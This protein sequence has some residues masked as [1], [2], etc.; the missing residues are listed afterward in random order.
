MPLYT[1]EEVEVDLTNMDPDSPVLWIRADPELL[2]LRN[3]AIRQPNYQWEYMLKYERDV[4]A[5]LQVRINV[6]S[7]KKK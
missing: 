5:Q 2:L 3:L 7:S 6:F 4:V 1:G